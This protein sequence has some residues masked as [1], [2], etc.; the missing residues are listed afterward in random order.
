M[1]WVKVAERLPR[2]DW[3]TLL[4]GDALGWDD[5]PVFGRLCECHDEWVEPDGKVV[6]LASG[7]VTHW[8][9]WDAP[10]KDSASPDISLL[11]V[12]ARVHIAVEAETSPS[13]GPAKLLL[14]EI[15]A[16]LKFSPAFAAEL[17]AIAMC[18]PL[19]A[20]KRGE[21]LK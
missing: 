21:Y 18:E 8:L 1:K 12:R 17:T 13:P 15:D 4:W 6:A 2:R 10:G 20:S 5:F 11:L 3:P 16:A 9:D 14:A 7:N 19:S